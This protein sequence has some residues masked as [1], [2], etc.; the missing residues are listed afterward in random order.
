MYDIEEPPDGSTPFLG[1]HLVDFAVDVRE[2]AKI[3]GDLCYRREFLEKDGEPFNVIEVTR[4]AASP[5]VELTGHRFDLI[6]EQ[7][8]VECGKNVAS[9]GMINESKVATGGR[10]VDS[11]L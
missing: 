4:N 8:R 2:I 1:N 10:V 3:E 11:V 9:S 5:G 7:R 6:K